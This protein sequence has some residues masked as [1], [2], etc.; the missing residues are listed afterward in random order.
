MNFILWDD[1]NR[2]TRPMSAA[3]HSYRDEGAASSLPRGVSRTPAGSPA[4]AAPTPPQQLLDDSRADKRNALAAPP[5]RP[6]GLHGDA[7]SAGRMGQAHGGARGER[8]VSASR[9]QKFRRFRGDERLPRE[10]ARQIAASGRGA[11]VVTGERRRPVVGTAVRWA[12]RGSG[13]VGSRAQLCFLCGGAL[14]LQGHDGLRLDKVPK[15]FGPCG[16]RLKTA[17]W[18]GGRCD[19]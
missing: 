1:L 13:A 11:C 2:P 17:R 14:R 18:L 15:S 3:H 6:P 5:S 8:L 4:R 9:R 16:G 7:L 12:G 10:T 19:G